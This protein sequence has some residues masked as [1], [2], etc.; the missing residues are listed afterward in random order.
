MVSTPKQLTAEHQQNLAAKAFEHYQPQL[1]ANQVHDLK[2][3][4]F[5]ASLQ[6][7]TIKVP[8]FLSRAHEFRHGAGTDLQEEVQACHRC[9]EHILEK[10]DA[11]KHTTSC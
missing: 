10:A 9:Y 11:G 7:Q 2:V 4:L 1:L 3:M 5:E 6:Q 8:S